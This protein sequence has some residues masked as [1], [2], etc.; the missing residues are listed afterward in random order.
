MLSGLRSLSVLLLLAL[1]PAYC[2][3]PGLPCSRPAGETSTCVC[4]T[5]DG[6]VDLRDAA[7]DNGVAR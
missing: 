3:P 4:Q 6:V 5:A 7:S 2:T 1:A